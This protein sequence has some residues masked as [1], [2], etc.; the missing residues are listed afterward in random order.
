MGAI[1]QLY[2]ENMHNKITP[3]NFIEG[4]FQQQGLNKLRVPRKSSTV[5]YSMLH[6]YRLSRI[7]RGFLQHIVEYLLQYTE[8]A[9]VGV[10]RGVPLSFKGSEFKLRSLE[11]YPKAHRA[12]SGGSNLPWRVPEVFSLIISK[13]T[14]P[15]NMA[16]VFKIMNEGKYVFQLPKTV[17]QA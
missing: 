9:Q 14:R 7:L 12:L 17:T 13:L 10:R 16:Q 8:W 11:F 4:P 6:K 5:C 15:E 1:R 2:G 3:M